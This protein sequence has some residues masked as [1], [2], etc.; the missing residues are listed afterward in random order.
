MSFAGW[1]GS[2]VDPA[3]ARPAEN[4]AT[5]ERMLGEAPLAVVPH[6][7]EPAA[8]SLGEGAA[9]LVAAHV[10]PMTRLE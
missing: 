8:A 10:K 4:L 6:L 5:L 1:V 9:R 7:A 2:A 3:L